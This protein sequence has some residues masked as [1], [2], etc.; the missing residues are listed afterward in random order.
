MLASG[1]AELLSLG[2]V[3]PFL[4]VSVMERLWQLPLIQVLAARVGFMAA[5]DLLMPATSPFAAAAAR[6]A[7]PA[8]EPFERLPGGKGG[9]DLL[10]A[11]HIVSTPL[12]HVRALR[13]YDHRH[14]Q[15]DRALWGP[16][17]CAVPDHGGGGDAGSAH[18]PSA[19]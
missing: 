16:Q 10:W 11:Y 6:G 9:L 17:C 1:A 12:V 14:H 4:A 3:L 2:A 18:G 7:D 15:P 13:G 5:S 19:D 8:D